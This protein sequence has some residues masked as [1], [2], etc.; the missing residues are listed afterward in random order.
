MLS[1][2][3]TMKR[4]WRVGKDYRLGCTR[5]GET[6]AELDADT[7]ASRLCHCRTSLAMVCPIQMIYLLLAG[8]RQRGIPGRIYG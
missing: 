5:R 6:S 8:C 7:L 2:F 3:V 4:A 1:K